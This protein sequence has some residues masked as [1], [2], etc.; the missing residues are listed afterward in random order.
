MSIC[1]RAIR[2]TPWAT[3]P[4]IIAG[5]L[6]SEAII[7]DEPP[8]RMPDGKPDFSGVWLIGD[9]P[10]PEK[11]DAQEWA[12]EIA[13]KRIANSLI[14]HPHNQ[15]LPGNP[16][17]PGAAAPFIAKFVH[18]EDLLVMLFE[19][20][21]GFRQV[22]VDGREHPEYPNPTWVGHSV[23]HWEGDTL[24]IDAIGFNDRGWMSLY[25]RSEALHIV[26]RYTRSE[27]GRIDAEM[28]VEDPAVYN[29]PWR[30]R[31]SYYL[32]PHVE[33]IE[34]VCENNKWAGGAGN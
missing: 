21:P 20:V 22:F 6:R 9:D 17:I 2:S 5:A 3:I 24:V 30:R 16:P 10:F 26:E 28:T 33:L 18:K 4:G 19:D 12:E 23:A 27:Y 1:R 32:V 8:P 13:E 7:P 14:D 15:C 34:Y 11:I 25:P 29:K 31:A